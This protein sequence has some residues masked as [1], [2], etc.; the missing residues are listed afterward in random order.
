[1]RKQ[2][3]AAIEAAL[4]LRDEQSYL[5]TLAFMVGSIATARGEP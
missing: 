5:T 4:T 2:K 3:S 1:M